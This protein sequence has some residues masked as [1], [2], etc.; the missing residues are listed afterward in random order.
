MEVEIVEWRYEHKTRWKERMTIFGK[1]T[2]PLCSLKENGENGTNWR[3]Y[4]I[5]KYASSSTWGHVPRLGPAPP[6]GSIGPCSVNAN[7]PVQPTPWHYTSVTV[8][9]NLVTCCTEPQHISTCSRTLPHWRWRWY[10]P[11]KRWKKLP[12]QQGD[13]IHALTTVITSNPVELT[14]LVCDRDVRIEILKVVVPIS[15]TGFHVCICLHNL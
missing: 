10:L 15:T 11:L 7:V 12:R 4:L 5:I 6:W 14:L 9:S 3:L 13:T 2:S 1:V 8:T